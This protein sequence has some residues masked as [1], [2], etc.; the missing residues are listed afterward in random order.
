MSAL[1]YIMDAMGQVKEANNM[2]EHIKT[3]IEQNKLY[4]LENDYYA[5]IVRRQ[6][7]NGNM[8]AANRW[9]E[10]NNATHYKNVNL[11]GVFLSFTACRAYI[12]S[13]DYNSAIDLLTKIHNFAMI[14][15]RPLDIIEACILLAVAYWKKKRTFQKKAMLFLETAVSLAYEHGYTQMFVNDG[16]EL[17]SMLQRLKKRTEQIGESGG[18][19][20]ASFV[21]ML[22]LKAL[23][24][25]NSGLTSTHTEPVLKYTDKQKAV[26]NLLCVGKSYNEIAEDLGIKR[27]TLRSHIALIYKKLGVTNGIDAVKKINSL[28]LLQK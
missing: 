13:G 11:Y 27:T 22:H 17:I 8:D 19:A 5:V 3:L 15:N 12:V 7:L 10:A 2:L 4:Y 16:A 21:K 14:Y 18:K 26:M 28:N 6:L 23:E 1:V 25:R 24:H 9:L 20:S